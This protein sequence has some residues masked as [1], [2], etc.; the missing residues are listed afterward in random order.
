[1]KLS[2]GKV[3]F[4]IEFDNGDVETIY[5]NPNDREFIQRV[6]NFENSINER[7]KNINVEKYKANIDD[8]IDINID[9]DNLSK[10]EEMTPDEMESLRKKIGA[11]IDIDKEYQN[12]LKDELNDIFKSDISS[13][14]FKYCE[15]M[16]N[17]IITDENGNETSKMFIM[18]FIEAFSEEIKKHQAKVS[19]AMKKHLDKYAK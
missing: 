11:V 10:L 14:V 3:A 7:I 1:M 9:I 19:P 5:F 12:A 4:P 13:K 16:D 6:M 15:P 17:V 2:T 8:G 18:Q